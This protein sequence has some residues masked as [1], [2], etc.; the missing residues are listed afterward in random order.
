MALPMSKLLF[1]DTS[2]IVALVNTRD[3]YHKAASDLSEKY[4]A[5]PLLTTQA[6]LLEI[7]GA[8]CGRYK[9][10]SI[11]IIDSFLAAD[12][13]E[14]VPFSNELFLRALDLYKKYVDKEWSLVDCISFLVMRDKK[15]SAALSADAHFNQAGFD[16][17]LI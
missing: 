5:Y 9:K 17:L 1:V 3:Q 6:V 10:A 13:V 8:L 4:Q 16:A 12:D 2:Y 15:I 14:V 11:S 7:S